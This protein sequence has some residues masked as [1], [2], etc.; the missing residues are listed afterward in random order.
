MKTGDA[1][2]A[3]T[4]FVLIGEETASE[5]LKHLNESEIETITREISSVGPIVAEEAEKAAEELYASLV[6]NSYVSDG[7]ID[8]AKKVILRTLGA[9]PARRIL[10]RVSSNYVASN[11]FEAIERLSPVQLSQ[12]I[13]NEHPQT[14]ALVLAHMKPSS[15]YELLE[16]LPEDLQ[17]DVAV[18]MAS[19]DTISQDVIQGIATVLEEKLKP[20][21]TFAHNQAYGG[22][23]AVAEL[24][25]RMDRRR[26]RAVLEKI[27]NDKP[28]VANSIRELMFVFDD[29]ATLDDMAIREILMRIDKKTIAQALKGATDQQQAQFFRNMSGR[30][31][32][33]MKE[34]MELMGPQKIKDVHAA[35]TRIVEIVR[36]LEEEGII[37]LGPGGGV[38]EYVV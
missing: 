25:N 24:L 29:I 28:E 30:A 20:V 38:D 32:E 31:V 22:I 11:A 35:Q 18:R 21:G 26:S 7:G 23:R 17:A 34:E 13:Q 27:D 19:L 6:A 5:V 37:T 2:M 9:G 14:I 16:S 1:K 8:Y 33:M 10:D 36:K 15:S 12:F 4:L 3:A